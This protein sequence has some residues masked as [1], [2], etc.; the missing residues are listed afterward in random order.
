MTSAQIKALCAQTTMGIMCLLL[1]L[2]APAY[3]ATH[4]ASM[5]I[6]LV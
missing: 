5:Q 4:G 2:T 3:G 6:S 1:A